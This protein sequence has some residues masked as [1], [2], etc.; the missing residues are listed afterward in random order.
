MTMRFRE[1]GLFLAMMA[2]AACAPKVDKDPTL[3]ESENTLALF[4]PQPDDPGTAELDER[5]QSALPSPIDTARV[6]VEGSDRYRLDIPKC[7]AEESAQER[8][9]REG[10]MTLDGFA[11]G[12]L[13]TASF[14]RALDVE[15]ARAF[16]PNDG[17]GSLLLI[18]PTA[19]ALVPIAATFA[20]DATNAKRSEWFK[21]TITPAE[22]LKEG[23]TYFAV[24]TTAL[25]DASGRPVGSD[26]VFTLLKSRTAL[27]NE[28]GHSNFAA[29]LDNA[30]AAALEPMRA[31]YQ[32]L[33]AALE[34]LMQLPRERVA[35]AWSFTTQSVGKPLTQVAGLLGGALPKSGGTVTQIPASAVPQIPKD[36]LCNVY[37]G[38]LTLKS[39]L[40]E[41]TG[42]FSPTGTPTPVE[43]GYRLITPETAECEWDGAKL[44][45]YAHG[46][47]RCSA[48]AL[49]VAS[50]L[51]KEGFATLAL[52]AP[53][54]GSRLATPPPADGNGDGCPDDSAI[55]A[56]LAAPGQSP[57]PFY[58]RDHLRE[59]ALEL[60][61]VAELAKTN[62]M[63]LLDPSIA[64]SAP[65]SVVLVGHSFGGVAGALAAPFAKFD[66]V[67]LNSASGGMAVMLE[68][69]LRGL[70][71]QQ[72]RQGSTEPLS[73]AQQAMLEATVGKMLPLFAWALEPAD[74]LFAPRAWAPSVPV[75][76]QVVVS[77]VAPEAPFH[78]VATQR[79]LAQALKGQAGLSVFSAEFSFEVEGAAPLC[80]DPLAVV[81]TLLRPCGA[82][83]AAKYVA[84]QRQVAHFARTALEGSP[85]VC[86]EAAASCD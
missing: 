42:T 33:F 64:S 16:N 56:L 17:S 60:A 9:L 65:A 28:H 22:R 62:P 85:K 35:V 47:G 79:A 55:P 31:A 10:L 7:S 57:N 6:K 8:A 37:S 38:T 70:V 54:S 1:S 66:G 51:A 72:V 11:A 43:V 36:A 61:Q 53:S 67:V 2:V 18:D 34:Q 3:T 86:E 84:M 24:V 5:C 71:E 73:A 59:W 32:P 14:S 25:K 4:A 15:S 83:A 19:Q 52:D 58:M 21:L 82:G 46:L 45:L 30:K 40:D 78:A 29:A 13:L 76:A 20:E 50:A 39:L 81:G 23:T 77:P 74:P 80:A 69:T 49:A 63:A 68:P 27:V 75:L 41:A 44:A 26:Q 48:D 12:T